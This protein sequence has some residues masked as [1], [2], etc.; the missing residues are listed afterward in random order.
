[1][2]RTCNGTIIRTLHAVYY[3]CLLNGKLIKQPSE[4]FQICPEC[5]RR[6]IAD[7]KFAKFSFQFTTF[8][9]LDSGE[10]IEFN[11]IEMTDE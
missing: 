7:E 3:R 4:P 2:K 11:N 9:L 6:I 10:I 8:L 5:G 1:M